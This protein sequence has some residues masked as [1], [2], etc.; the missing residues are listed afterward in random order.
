MEV[1]SEVRRQKFRG[2]DGETSDSGTQ[3]TVELILRKL[4]EGPESVNCWKTIPTSEQK[5]SVLR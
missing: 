3:I 5:T 4:A 2:Q 1:R